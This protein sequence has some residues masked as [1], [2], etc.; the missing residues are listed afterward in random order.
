MYKLKLLLRSNKMIRKKVNRL[1]LEITKMATF[2]NTKK[3]LRAKGK[4]PRMIKNAAKSLIKT[5]KT[6]DSDNKKLSTLYYGDKNSNSPRFWKT[7]IK[8]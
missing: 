1:A 7:F 4:R 3:I 8:S 6:Q 2:A 5:L